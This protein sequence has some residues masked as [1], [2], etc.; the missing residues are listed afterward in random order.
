MTGRPAD[1]STQAREAYFPD[2]A[3]DLV[4]AGPIPLMLTGGIT[5]RVTAERVLWNGVA[6]VGMAPPSPRTFPCAGG[7]TARR[8]A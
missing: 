4:R 3:E 7:T 6:V 1:D 8:T 5:R 2:L